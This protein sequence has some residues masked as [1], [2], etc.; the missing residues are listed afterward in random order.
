MPQRSGARRAIG[1][2]HLT[3]MAVRAVLITRDAAA[4]A[5]ELVVK[6]SG[7]AFLA[8][9]DCERELD[10]IERAID[11]QIPDALPC[12]SRDDARAIL[13]CVRLI[14]D[15]GRIGDLLFGVTERLRRY[16]LRLAKGD[17]ALLGQMAAVVESMLQDIHRGFASHDARLAWDVIRRDAQIDR[18]RHQ[19]FRQHLNRKHRRDPAESIHVLLMAQAFERSGDHAKN[20][21]EELFHLVEG[22]SLWHVSPQQQRAEFTRLAAEETKSQGQ[23]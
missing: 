20:L 21:A 1:S 15:T 13:A 22:R 7:M 2:K 16:Q 17:T 10:E 8:V 11:T 19:L 3:Q 9:R 12:I 18:A 23:A 5:R 14:T 6:P 4:N